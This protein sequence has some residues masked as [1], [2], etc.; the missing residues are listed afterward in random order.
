MK[1]VGIWKKRLTDDEA[2]V[3][4]NRDL[5]VEPS[6]VAGQRMLL[7]DRVF[8][9]GSFNQTL[10]LSDVRQNLRPVHADDLKTSHSLLLRVGPHPRHHLRQLV[11]RGGHEPLKGVVVGMVATRKHPETNVV[12]ASGLKS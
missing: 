2:A 8:L 3:C 7:P 10:P 6:D 5:G 9:A 1:V 4:I 11:P 12:S